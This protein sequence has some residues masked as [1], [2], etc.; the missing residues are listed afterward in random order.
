MAYYAWC[1]LSYLNGRGPLL[2]VILS[3][4]IAMAIHLSAAALLPSLVFVIGVGFRQP[5]RRS[6]WGE[7]LA[8]GLAA[9]VALTLL[10]QLGGGYDLPKTLLATVGRIASPDSDAPGYIASRTHTLDVIN[11]QLLIGPLGLMLIAAGLAGLKTSGGHLGVRLFLMALVLPYLA[12]SLIAGDSNLGYARN[13]DLLAPTGFV[14][15]MAGLFLLL[16]QVR[17]PALR[18]ATLALAIALSLFHTAPWIAVNASLD[19]GLARFATLPLGGGRTESTLGLWHF[20]QAN[21]SEAEHWLDRSIRANPSNPRAHYWVGRVYS[22]TGRIDAAAAA[23]ERAR[24]IRP[25]VVTFRLAWINSLVRLGLL[26][27]A[28]QEASYL[29]KTDPSNSRRWALL[30]AILLELGRGS[31]ALEAFQ[32]ARILDLEEKSYERLTQMAHSPPIGLRI[33][34]QDLDA[35][36]GM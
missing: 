2:P 14:F 15:I 6:F 21:Y 19:R 18:N 32:R 31:E 13:W 10:S 24:D 5:G 28:L 23:F 29:A 33:P 20:R 22:A 8:G 35:L 1:A 25:D 16:E 26:E 34:R 27:P 36:T 7:V 11:E 4:L 9:A 17:K 3:C 12:V 30:G